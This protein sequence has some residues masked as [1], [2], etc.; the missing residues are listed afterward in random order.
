MTHISILPTEIWLQILSYIEGHEIID[1][2]SGL[3]CFF[4]QLLHSPHLRVHLRVKHDECEKNLSQPSRKRL[5]L[6]SVRSL[7]Y[8]RRSRNALFQFLH[9]NSNHLIH[10]EILSI[11]LRPRTERSPYYLLFNVLDELPALKSLRIRGVMTIPRCGLI[12]FADLHRKIFS[13]RLRLEQCELIFEPQY[14]DLSGRVWPGPSTIRFLTIEKITWSNL[15]VILSTTPNLTVL[16]TYLIRSRADPVTFNLPSLR[17]LTLCL[18][19]TEFV[20]LEE[21]RRLAPS[22]N[23]L[24]IYGKYPLADENYF[25]EHLWRELFDGID[26][27]QVELGHMDSWTSRYESYQKR[28]AP[29]INEGWLRLSVDSYFLYVKIVFRSK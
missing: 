11:Y 29:L 15:L 22:L 14:F 21:I 8:R 5:P 27:Y 4:D 18:H 10:L 25:R 19:E 23:Y 24:W 9:W 6:E 20:V 16:E 2:F 1:A 3:N 7:G 28:F 17:K 13:N 26:F 12:S